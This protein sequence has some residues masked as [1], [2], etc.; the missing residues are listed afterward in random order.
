MSERKYTD[1][2]TVK[3]LECC[4]INCSC[5][6]CPANY[7]EHD[8]LCARYIKRLALD[9]INRQKAEVEKL[10]KVNADLNESLRL[11]AE[12]NKDLK[13]EV[14]RLKTEQMMAEGYADALEERAKVE[15]IK[16]FVRRFKETTS[17]IVGL[18]GGVEIY[19]TKIY[20]IRATSFDNPVAEMT[21]GEEI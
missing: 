18:R 2:Q 11:A 16:E 3:A 20:Q 21:E 10:Q 19:E 14:E 5:D 17:S 6:G 7:E 15:S 8:D 12:A 1:E 9:L 4:A 13:A